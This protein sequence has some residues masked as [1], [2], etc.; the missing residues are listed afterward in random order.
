MISKESL[1]IIEQEAREFFQKAGISGDIQVKSEDESTALIETTLEEP[2]LFIGEKGQTLFEIQ[3]LLK[4]IIRRKIPEQIYVSLDI[5]EYKK[6]KEHYIRDLAKNS[7]DD[8]ALLK[9]ER[10]LP[11]MPAAERRI[12]HVELAD[13]DDVTSESTGEGTDRKVVIKPKTT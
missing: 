2:Q 7:A 3:H 1:Q 4:A 10:E 12:V 5:N 9:K 13:R 11:P 6:N 8:V